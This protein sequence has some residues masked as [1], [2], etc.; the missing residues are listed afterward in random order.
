L[1]S[2]SE[3]LTG[4]VEDIDRVESDLA[5]ALTHADEA[6]SDYDKFEYVD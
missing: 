2:I 1:D 4:A 5:M 6:D 3:T